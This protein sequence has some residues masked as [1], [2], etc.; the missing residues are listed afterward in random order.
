MYAPLLFVSDDIEFHAQIPAEVSSRPGQ[1]HPEAPI[2]HVQELCFQG[3]GIHRC[4]CL[5][6]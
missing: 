4:D 5:P 3:N 6:K 2:L 1:R